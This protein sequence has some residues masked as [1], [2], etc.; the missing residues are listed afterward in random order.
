MAKL[1]AGMLATAALRVRIKTSLKNTK[2]GGI[3][4]GVANTHQPAKKNTRKIKEKVLQNKKNMSS[5]VMLKTN[6]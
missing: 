4:K 1:V 5:S 6:Q 3:C 2:I